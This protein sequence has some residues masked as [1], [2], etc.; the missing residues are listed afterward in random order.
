MALPQRAGVGGVAAA[1][2]GAGMDVPSRAV[3]FPARV[4]DP[5]DDPFKTPRSAWPDDGS[6]DSMSRLSP[7]GSRRKEPILRWSAEYLWRPPCW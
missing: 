5:N 3:A 2:I 1:A 4:V 7:L 6:D